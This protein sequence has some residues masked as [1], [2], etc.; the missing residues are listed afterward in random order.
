MTPAD[1]SRTVLHTVRCAVEA[2]ELRAA[3]PS[4][5]T[6]R[7]PPRPDCGDYAT[8]I[9]LRL[10]KDS[11]RPAREVAEI[12]RRRLAAEPGIARVDIAE[13]GFLNITLASAPQARI[14]RSL[15]RAEGPGEPLDLPPPPPD[16]LAR[17]GPDAARW[18]LLSPPGLDRDLLLVQ[19]ESNPLFRVRY[20]H[21]RT[22][23]LLRNARDL[24]F[25]PQLTDDAAEL[26]DGA[27]PLFAALAD[28]P[29]IAAARDAARLARHLERLADA[30]LRWQAD[31]P[32]LP[33]GEEKPSAVH[34]ARLA[35]AEATGK[36]LADGL[37][38]LGV[39]APAHL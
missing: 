33:R 26:A 16:L 38:Q 39:T 5:V 10:A 28:H 24:G 37:H 11:G 34:R 4:R 30:F 7:V 29:R 12:L 31:C 17:L 14:V 18:S 21:A 25:G 9:A 32:V 23:A 20:A 13:P 22:A 1:V 27:G 19:R 6:V 35:V 2:D 8:N 3:V 15:L 36:V